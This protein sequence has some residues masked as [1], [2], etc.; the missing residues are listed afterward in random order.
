MAPQ[1]GPYNP[2]YNSPAAVPP[3]AATATYPSMNYSSTR[4]SGGESTGTSP[5]VVSNA[6]ADQPSA[7]PYPNTAGGNAMDAAAN[8]SAGSSVGDRYASRPPDQDAGTAL[9]YDSRSTGSPPLAASAANDRYSPPAAGDGY[10]NPNAT[11]TPDAGADRYARDNVA[12]GSYQPGNTGYEAGNTG[13]NPP[14]VDPYKSPA[15]ANNYAAAPRRDPGYRPG[16]TSDYRPSDGLRPGPAGGT[17]AD[18]YAT[19]PSSVRPA[20][21]DA[22]STAPPPAYPSS[23]TGDRYG[24]APANRYQ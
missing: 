21:Y 13:Y 1:N 20:G 2:V 9:N 17:P 24:T 5:A 10:V 18:R 16:G 19:P 7:T 14:G 15:T 12:H 11:S 4:L 3:G 23:A 22:G 6:Y 8:P